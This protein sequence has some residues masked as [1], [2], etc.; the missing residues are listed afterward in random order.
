MTSPPHVEDPGL[1][2]TYIPRLD[3]ILGGGIPQGHL[4]LFNGS[5]GTMKST[6][7]YTLLHRGAVNGN[8]GL[9][10]SIEQSRGSILRQMERLGMPM[11]AT[12]GRLKLT[13][14][15]EVKKEMADSEGNWREIIMEYIRK[16]QGSMGF[17][18]F[19]L[20][21]LESFKAMT[22]HSFSRQDLKDL[23]DWFKDLGITVLVIT[24]NTSDN[25]DESNQ[26]EAYLSDGI[27]ELLMREMGDS[28]VQRWI[29]IV[30]MRG[31]NVDARYYSMF[32]NGKDFNL[33]LPLANQPF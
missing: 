23:F 20:D 25:Y 2:R 22:E 12:G 8:P 30:K 6:I 26:G 9:Y 17:K 27:I 33:A 16:Q 15:R 11:E 5:P 29:R 10:L 1:L 21:S 18:S 3:D 4:V 14:I 13:D 7:A 31:A 32:H 24:E 19:V 28:R